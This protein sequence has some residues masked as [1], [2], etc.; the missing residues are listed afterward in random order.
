M[1]NQNKMSLVYS[2]TLKQAKRRNETPIALQNAQVEFVKQSGYCEEV[3]GLMYV[4]IP[5]LFGG[6]FEERIDQQNLLNIA[7]WA[8][9]NNIYSPEAV[10]IENLRLERA[11]AKNFSTQTRV[12]RYKA[13]KG[14][15]FRKAYKPSKRVPTLKVK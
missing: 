6:D 14:I 11:A 13:E 4:R 15:N 1:M 8:L 9:W 2:L 7:V 3:K 12:Q 5:Y 10:R